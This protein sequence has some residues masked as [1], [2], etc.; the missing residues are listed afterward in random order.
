MNNIMDQYVNQIMQQAGIANLPEDFKK[1]YVAKL[2]AEAQR[3]LGIMAMGEMDEQGLKDFEQLMEEN[4]EQNP[5]ALME[6]F[7]ARIPDFENKVTVALKQFAE[8]F[9]DGAAKLKKASN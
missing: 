9:V 7:K 3:R 6:F 1:D 5:Q 4:K 8:E 2:S